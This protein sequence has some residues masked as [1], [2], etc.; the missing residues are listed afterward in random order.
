MTKAIL[1]A[2]KKETEAHGAR[3]L[4]LYVPTSNINES[5]KA[6]VLLE[7]WARES[8]TAFVNLRERFLDLEDSEQTLLYRGHWTPFGNG[9]VADIVA[10]HIASNDL[11]IAAH[12]DPD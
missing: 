10:T 5:G 12:Q 1:E 8:E 2:T 6:E 4:L 3:L 9:V 7:A 11:L